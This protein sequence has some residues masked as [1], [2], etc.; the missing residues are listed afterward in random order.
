MNLRE[1]TKE[2]LAKNNIKMLS[3]IINQFRFKLGWNYEKIQEWF[4]NKFN[5]GNDDFDDLMYS[6]DKSDELD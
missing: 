5:V 4:F 3:N 1:A 6:C 2:A